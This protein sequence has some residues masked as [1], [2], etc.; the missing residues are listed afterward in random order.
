MKRVLVPLILLL[1]SACPAVATPTPPLQ[2]GIAFDQV[3]TFYAEQS[4]LPAPSDFD[5]VFARVQSDLAQH[6]NESRFERDTKYGQIFRIAISGDLERIDTPGNPVYRVYNS[7]AK[8]IKIVD[9]RRHTFVRET[10]PGPQVASI[11]AGKSVSPSP[12]PSPWPDVEAKLGID[13]TALPPQSADGLTLTGAK[14]TVIARVDAPTCRPVQLRAEITMYATDA[15]AEPAADNE[16]ES[17]FSFTNLTAGS[18][19]NVPE[20][21]K[22]AAALLPTFP[23]FVML[24]AR[25]VIEER[26]EQQGQHPPFVTNIQVVMRGHV[27]ALK[28]ADTA[29]LFETPA[30]YKWDPSLAD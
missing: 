25:E 10:A 14:S 29:S 5:S 9:T 21:A 22:Q 15:F 16:Y 2:T 18:Q 1:V 26:V 7:K 13:T 24:T 30:G 4:P 20:F 12:R 11:P 17:P 23:H 3:M 19:C 28:P 8:W 6:A 27:R